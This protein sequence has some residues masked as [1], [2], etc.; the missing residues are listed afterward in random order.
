MAPDVDV[1]TLR[2]IVDVAETGSLSAAAARRGMSQP[3]ASA[4]VREFEARWR[5]GVLR[6]SSRGSSLTTDGEAVVSWARQ[7]L[8]AVD[9]MRASMT[10]LSAQRR[11][12][13]AVAASLTI[14][15][16]LLPHWLGELHVRRPE[17][18]PVLKVVNSEAVAVAVRSGAVD[19]G[20]IESTD[21]PSGLARRQVGS[22]RLL[23]VVSPGH[24]GAG[25]GRCCGRGSRGGRSGFCGKREAG[26]GA[27]SSVRW[28]R[29]RSS[30]SRRRPRW[31][32][33][34]P[35]WPA[36]GRQWCRRDRS[37]ERSG[38]V[39]SWPSR[40]CWTC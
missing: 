22:D 11:A 38:P 36:S 17:V 13:M 32:S 10:A 25:A 3:A 29:N 7:V 24:P 33:S 27:R 37:P 15:E 19:I 18:R 40:R 20:F 6:R 12:G 1:E 28:V 23:V 30:R 9:T 39:A 2:L 35:R 16:Y 5:L 14:A 34:A 4:R 31:P 8:H 21:L 26:R